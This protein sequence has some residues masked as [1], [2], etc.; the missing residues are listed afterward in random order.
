ME[1]LLDGKV[2]RSPQETSLN[3]YTV[4]SCKVLSG[5]EPDLRFWFYFRTGTLDEQIVKPTISLVITLVYLSK[6]S[7]L[8]TLEEDKL[9]YSDLGDICE[10]RTRVCVR[11]CMSWVHREGISVSGFL[12]KK[13][14]C[15]FYSGRSLVP[16]VRVEDTLD[17]PDRLSISLDRGKITPT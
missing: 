3:I 2:G 5:G 17:L 4:R 9:R 1:A 10:G 16:T 8:R 14:R 15:N 12:F 6:P 13:K 7:R 11:K